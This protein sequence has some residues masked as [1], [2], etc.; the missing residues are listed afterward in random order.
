MF[1]FLRNSNQSNVFSPSLTISS[2]STIILASLFFVSAPSIKQVGHWP[3][4]TYQL[5]RF[6]REQT[7]FFLEFFISKHHTNSWPQETVGNIFDSTMSFFMLIES[8]FKNCSVGN[9]IMFAVSENLKAWQKQSLNCTH[10]SF[11]VEDG[12]REVQTANHG[13]VYINVKI[14]WDCFTPPL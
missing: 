13:L 9:N 2:W 1:F 8:F 4:E 6:G 5:A 12:F 3:P 10:T 7:A 14:L 11:F